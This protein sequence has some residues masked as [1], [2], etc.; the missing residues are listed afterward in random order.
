MGKLETPDW[1]KEG[2]KS[3]EDWENKKGIK[4]K[5]EKGKTYKVKVCPKCG[6]SEV[7]IILGQEEGKGKSEWECKSCK[8]KGRNIEEK[9]MSEDEFL[10][11]LEE[12]EKK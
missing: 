4:R 3:K 12:K 7:S 2:Y 1:I 9:S 8:W 10:E 6:R 11:H 5:K